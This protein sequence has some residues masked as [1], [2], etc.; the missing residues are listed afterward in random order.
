MI[1]R[2]WRRMSAGALFTAALAAAPPPQKADFLV[3]G[4][5]S[6][7]T[8]FDKYQQE[9]S[10]AQKRA[11]PSN[12]PLRIVE[13]DATLGDRITPAMKVQ[14]NNELLCLLKTD[15]GVLAEEK[16]DSGR[17][18]YTG[19]TV[20][21]DTVRVVRGGALRLAPPGGAPAAPL[22]QGDLLVR[23]FSHG[24]RF[25]AM[26]PGTAAQYGWCDLSDRGAWKPLARE[27]MPPERIDPVL[28]RR[29]AARLTEANRSYEKFCDYFNARTSRHKTP[30]RWSIDT[31][32]AAVVCSLSDPSGMAEDLGESTRCLAGDIENMLIGKPF[33]VDHTG[34]RITIGPQ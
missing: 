32:A 27:S 15:E 23:F 7:Y 9:M 19:C 29:I 20:L 24:G 2:Q 8:V 33:R 11:F 16:K 25:Y 17:R 13:R 10:A 30:P 12:I 6:G 21:G 18:E 26:L 4:S 3:A 14:W 5:L 31:S 28:V 22:K 1:V 34:G